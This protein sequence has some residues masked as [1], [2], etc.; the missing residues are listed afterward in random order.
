MN[1]QTLRVSAG[2]T[3]DFVAHQLGV[4][5]STVRNWEKGVTEPSLS[6]AKKIAKLYGISV[7]EIE[8]VSK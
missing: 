7:G 6:M 4:N 1:L 2:W 3:R 5:I 8:E